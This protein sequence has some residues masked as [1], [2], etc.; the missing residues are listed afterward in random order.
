[1]GQ[2]LDK[3]KDLIRKRQTEQ[4]LRIM[5]KKQTNG[6]ISSVEDFSQ[7]LDKLIR[8]LNQTHLQPTL[9]LLKAAKVTDP[10]THNYMLERIQDDLV[11]AF[12]ETK[13]I[14]EVQQAHDILIRNVT[15]KNLRHGLAELEAK[16]SVYEFLNKTNFGFDSAIFSTFKESRDDRSVRAAGQMQTLFK[17]PRT[18]QSYKTTEDAYIDLVG[19]KL[20][21]ALS[22]KEYFLCN[23]VKTIFDI[24]THQSQ[25][26]TEEFALTNIIDNTKGTYWSKD[27]FQTERKSH[28]DCK[29]EFELNGIRSINFLEIETPVTAQPFYLYQ[30]HYIDST[31]QVIELST[32]DIK[33]NFSN[34]FTFKPINTS[35]I[36]LTFR[37]KNPYPDEFQII[38]YQPEKYS[39]IVKM[40][41]KDPSINLAKAYPNVKCIETSVSGWTYS[42]S[43]DN[44]RFGNTKFAPQSIY[45]SKPLEIEDVNQI[46]LR[47]IE[48]RPAS[49]TV[50]GQII[51][52]SHTY[53]DSQLFY[54]SIEY[55]VVRENLDSQNNIV[56]TKKFPILPTGVN[57][58]NHERLILTERYSTSP[59]NFDT[60]STCF[61]TNLSDGN[62]N[63]YANGIL[64]NP[65]EWED[66]TEEI[67]RIPNMGNSMSMKIHIHKPYPDNIYTV[68]YNPLKSTTMAIPFEL[69]QYSIN[70]LNVVDLT[71]DMSA[72]LV[73]NQL[74]VLDKGNN[75]DRIVK[76]RFY[77]V[78]ILRNNT[79]DPTLTP[80]VEEYMLLL[81]SKNT[82]K[83]QED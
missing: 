14:E 25:Y 73:Q 52:S 81:G 72:R 24:D 63:L 20:T 76:S 58:I 7:K 78:I 23:S 60:G 9:K 35:K 42:I 22:K 40:A 79:S 48:T 77:I 70:G 61:F 44:V 45:V 11:A 65:N 71:G 28:I 29:L 69:N 31:G 3:F 19:E 21:L 57:R 12:E 47:T 38:S 59:H 34:S 80:A 43:I 30:V 50:N 18:N 51:Q 27:F 49:S 6:E 46:G 62:V 16:V 55:W 17:D 75:A 56:S 64:M 8:E 15:L 13:N 1:M 33:L 83:F 41:I 68:S 82:T 5:S 67:S 66:V 4:V 2:Y 32:S 26:D 37:L 39:E 53:D 36:I 54:G 10:E 74:I